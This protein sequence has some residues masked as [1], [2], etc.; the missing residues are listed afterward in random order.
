M[1]SLGVPLQYACFVCRKSFKR[2]QFSGSI[3]RFMTSEHAI[4]QIRKL[5]ALN[6]HASTNVR[7]AAGKHITWASIS[8]RQSARK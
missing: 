6:S 8:K 2:P 4:G 5:N 7:T 3:N 1:K